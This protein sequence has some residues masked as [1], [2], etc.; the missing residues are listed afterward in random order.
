[1]R[2]GQ[3]R[4][5]HRRMGIRIH[6][7]RHQ[8]QRISCPSGDIHSRE[9]I[10][11]SLDPNLEWWGPNQSWS[12]MEHIHRHMDNH[13]HIHRMHQHLHWQQQWLRMKPT[14]KCT[15]EIAPHFWDIYHCYLPKELFSSWL[16]RL[17]LED[18]KQDLLFVLL[19]AGREPIV[20]DSVHWHCPQRLPSL[21]TEN[22]PHQH[23]EHH[24]LC[25]VVKLYFT[26]NLL[27]YY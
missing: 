5:E 1:M 12:Q 23:T 18:W 7:R 2:R 20:V 19:Y 27:H 21:I 10:L 26:H 24:N 15:L 14:I 22:I 16:L 6:G 9:H 11:V 25:K 17:T 3:R 13:I 8:H 4:H